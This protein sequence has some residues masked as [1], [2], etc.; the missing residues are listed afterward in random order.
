MT[1]STIDNR[2]STIDSGQQP[3]ANSQSFITYPY[4]QSVL[5][6]KLVKL[7][8]K[9]A[10]LGLAPVVAKFDLVPTMQSNEWGIQ[11]EVIMLHVHLEGV[12]PRINGWT[13]VCRNV[14]VRNVRIMVLSGELLLSRIVDSR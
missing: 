13:F 8:R 10:K 9:S 3:T 12:A 4:N 5:E 6:E 7:N 11:R 14:A 2:L 1:D